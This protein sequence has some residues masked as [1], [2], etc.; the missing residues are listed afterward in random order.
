MT[1]TWTR[2]I[3]DSPGTTGDPIDARR[4]PCG[5]HSTPAPPPGIPVAASTPGRLA[6]LARA[7]ARQAG[8]HWF[9][10]SNA[11]HF[12]GRTPRSRASSP[13][14]RSSSDSNPRPPRG[15]SSWGAEPPRPPPVRVQERP[16]LLRSELP[17]RALRRPSI[18]LRRTRTRDPHGVDHPGG[19]SPPDP[20][21]FESR[22]AHHFFGRTPRSRASSPVDRSSSDSNPRPPRGRSSWGAEP[23]RPP[24]VRVQERPPLLRS[25]LSGRALRRPSI[26]LRRTRTRDPQGVDHPGGP[27]P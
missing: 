1:R 26:G 20:H 14:D 24:P 19:P 4:P 16:P 11:H 17:G 5:A 12:F 23:P 15:R 3:G 27:S 6:Q 25:E 21:R 18:G 22:N 2:R 10:S 7:P 8:G 9:E 13:V